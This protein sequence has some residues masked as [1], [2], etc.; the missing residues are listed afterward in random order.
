MIF[1]TVKEG[2]LEILDECLGVFCVEVMAIVGSCTL[3]F[4]EFRAYGASTFFEENDPISSRRWL[5]DM[6][7]AFRTIFYP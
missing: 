3:S 7:N 2:N 6:A 5:A 4:C 1:G